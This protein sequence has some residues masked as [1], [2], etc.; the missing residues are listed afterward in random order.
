MKGSIPIRTKIIVRSLRRKF[1][2][3]RISRSLASSRVPMSWFVKPTKPTRGFG[4]IGK[5]SRARTLQQIKEIRK[6][7]WS[8]KAPYT[9][10]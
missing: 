2:T 3:P 5:P 7:Y 9:Y 6:K 4:E 10:A 1:S 8:K